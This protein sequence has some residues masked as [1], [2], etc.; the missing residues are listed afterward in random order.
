MS[1]SSLAA[2]LCRTD[3]ASCKGDM[4]TGAD[5][6]PDPRL[7]ATRVT[8]GGWVLSVSPARMEDGRELGWYPPQ[9]VALGLLEA[10]RYRDRGVKEREAIMSEL[11]PREDGRWGWPPAKAPQVIDFVSDLQVAV[12]PP[13]S[14]R[15]Q[16][17]L[18]DRPVDRAGEHH[19]SQ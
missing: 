15:R 17:H 3:G 16:G 8:T 2:P 11:E 1:E 4:D 12:L 6:T 9:P 14:P 7:V 10:K 18:A 19:P 5:Y 13:R